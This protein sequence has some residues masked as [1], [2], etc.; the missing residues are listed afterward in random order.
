MIGSHC[1]IEHGAG[2]AVMPITNLIDFGTETVNAGVSVL[3]VICVSATE[4]EDNAASMVITEKDNGKAHFE[5]TTEFEAVAI[6][7]E[8]E[9]ETNKVKA[10]IELCVKAEE[11]GDKYDPVDVLELIGRQNYTPAQAAIASDVKEI[12]GDNYKV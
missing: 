5:F 2:I 8:T 6:L 4:D 11:M 3:A 12:Y 9:A 1:F 10:F 7:T